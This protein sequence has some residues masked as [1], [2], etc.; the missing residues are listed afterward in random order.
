MISTAYG[1]SSRE[2]VWNYPIIV[3]LA[4]FRSPQLLHIKCNAREVSTRCGPSELEHYDFDEQAEDA[5]NIEVEL[6]PSAKSKDVG[7]SGTSSAELM[8]EM[9]DMSLQIEKK[10][11]KH[12][13]NS[14]QIEVLFAPLRA[15][16]GL[17]KLHIPYK[18]G[19][20]WTFQLNI[21]VRAA[22]VDDDINIESQLHCISSVCF[23]L[24]LNSFQDELKASAGTNC[25]AT[26]FRAYLTAASPFQF[27]VS[28]KGQGGRRRERRDR[29]RRD[30]FAL[31]ARLLVPLARRGLGA[32]RR[33]RCW[34]TTARRWAAPVLAL[35]LRNDC[36]LYQF[37][38]FIFNLF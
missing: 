27:D 29:R 15:F 17:S 31:P 38:F 20:R 28:P 13:A 16:A 22:E 26:P 6:M 30:R 33:R 14:L 8:N 5:F 1:A 11:R 37:C 19:V 25:G 18:Q 23:A 35:I 34:K 3:G 24:N 10:L 21:A 12:G 7:G 32:Q 2:L 36:V 4:E 9:M